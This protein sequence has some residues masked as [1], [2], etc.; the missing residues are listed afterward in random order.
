MQNF[1]RNVGFFIRKTSIFSPEIVEN[2]NI[3]PLRSR[4]RGAMNSATASGK[5]KLVRIL[6]GYRVYRE[7]IGS[8]VLCVIDFTCMHCL[9]DEKEKWR[10]WPKYIHFKRCPE[11]INGH[12]FCLNRY[13]IIKISFFFKVRGG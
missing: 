2:H 8:N 11:P 1:N 4:R 12:I 6:P 10:H 13:I 7:N 9:R 3:N 5:N